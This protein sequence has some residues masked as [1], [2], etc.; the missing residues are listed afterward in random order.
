LAIERRARFRLARL[1][2]DRDRSMN[3]ERS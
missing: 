1:R 2:E 3:G